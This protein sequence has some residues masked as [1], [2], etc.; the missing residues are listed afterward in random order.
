MNSVRTILVE[1]STWNNI[2]D[3]FYQF[4]LECLLREEVGDHGIVKAIDG[5]VERGY[6]PGRFRANSFDPR[7]DYEGDHVVFSGPILTETFMDLYAPYIRTIVDRGGSYSLIS[8]HTYLRAP[9]ID[10]LKRFF[11]VYPPVAIS[12]RDTLTYELMRGVA[13]I[14]RDGLCFAFFLSRT[15]DP[16]EMR[17]NHLCLSWYNGPEPSIRV[18]GDLRS[19]MPAEVIADQITVEEAPKN[20]LPW[21][22]A[23]HL[24]W[25][26]GLPSRIANVEVV[27]PVHGL[28]PF[29]HLTFSKP[30]SYASYNPI[31]FLGLYRSCV[32]CVTDR[33]HAGVAALSFGRPANIV[34]LDDRYAIFERAPLNKLSN[35]FFE[36]SNSGLEKELTDVRQ[37]LRGQLLPA[38]GLRNNLVDGAPSGVVRSQ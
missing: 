26:R 15:I 18:K 9:L 30:N 1:N 33:V 11:A 2:G 16:P 32:A 3:A 34:R 6:R 27:R 4:P 24:E 35:G 13:P 14:E 28:Y 20:K 12:T 10:V 22:I 37:W 29:A 25:R 7:P 23:R 21:R 19:D 5:P 8:V 38:I 17:S 36:L 31:S